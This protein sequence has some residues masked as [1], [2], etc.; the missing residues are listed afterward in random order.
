[1]PTT[2]EPATAAAVQIDQTTVFSLLGI[3]AVLA[4]AYTLSLRALPVHSSTKTR[5]LFVWH[6]FDALIHF[7]FEGSFLWNCFFVSA[8][9]YH[10]SSSSSSSSSSPSSPSSLLPPN[11][12][13]LALPDRT[14]GA[15]HG[16]G[17]FSALWQEYAKADRRWAGTDL[18]VVSLELLTVFVG[19]PLALCCADMVRRAEWGTPK[20]K[21]KSKSESKAKS[22]MGVVDNGNAR[23][24]W[25]VV[26]ATGELY[27]GS[28]VS[29]LEPPRPLTT[30]SH[31][32]AG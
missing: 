22:E 16:A 30:H 21:S 9:Y 28:S 13:F 29:S 31:P 23:W 3:V 26:L 20:A 4:A 14:F 27:G 10:P 1:M 17:P 25:M 15:A 5:V 8:P 11:V 24:F 19:G 6:L 7:I 2:S 32:Q 12:H 18:T